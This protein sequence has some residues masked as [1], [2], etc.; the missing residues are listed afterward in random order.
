MIAEKP[1]EIE[2]I[3]PNF[4]FVERGWMNANQFVFKGEKTVLIDTGDIMGWTETERVLE[5]SGVCLS[6][7]DLIVSTHSH[8]DHIGGNHFIQERSGCSIA[9]HRIDRS[10]IENLDDWSTWWRFFHQKGKFFRVDQSLENDDRIDLGEGI[11]LQVIHTPGHA[12]G[13]ICLYEESSQFLISADALWEGGDMGVINTIIEGN[14]APFLAEASL[15]RLSKL[16]VKKVFPGH[17]RPF[18]DFEGAVKKGLQRLRHFMNHP[19]SMARDHLKKLIIYMLL[20]KD[21][22]QKD[23]MLSYLMASNWYPIVVKRYLDEAYKQVY[24]SILQELV[25]RGLV[26]EKDG[27]Y[28]STVRP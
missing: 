2:Q 7:V 8:G 22:I 1:F 3:L 5:E 27:C 21:G 13:G 6:E 11:S 15:Q 9:M 18:E 16:K 12:S 26:K 28:V 23:R 14:I 20:M 4:Y 19:R 25:E 24:C 10:F 17:G